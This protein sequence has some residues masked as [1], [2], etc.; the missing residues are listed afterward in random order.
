M[1]TL[2]HEPNPSLDLSIERIVDVSPELVW[3]GWT[4]PELMKQW[5]APKPWTT[6]EI[7][8]D[9]RPGGIFRTSMRGPEGEAFDG[10]GCVLE[11]VP[12]E[13][14]VWTSAMGPGY[15][16]HPLSVVE[17]IPFVF[18]AII[19]MEPHEGGTKYR[20]LVVHADEESKEKH[21]AMG[22]HDG[23]GTVFNQLVEV[24]KAME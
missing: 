15:R 4:T 21:N 11:V 9:L 22:F 16:P 19:T 3:K 23:W 6:P 7:E 5:F 18:T 1:N 24:V 17:A 10:K 8:L 2:Q 20:A 14:L 12:N 13:K